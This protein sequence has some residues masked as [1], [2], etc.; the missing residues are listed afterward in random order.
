MRDESLAMGPAFSRWQHLT[1]EYA[2]E[3]HALQRGDAS[4]ATRL[5]LLAREMQG[6][7]PFKGGHAPPAAAAAA[8]AP[9]GKA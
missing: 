3:V 6:L 8:A 5:A 2:A 7:W 9:S 4:A 1:D